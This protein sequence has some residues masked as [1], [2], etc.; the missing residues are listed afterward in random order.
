MEEGIRRV[1]S[2]LSISLD[3]VVESS[4]QWQ[5]EFDEQTRA[6]LTTTLETSD[7][8][9]VR[10]AGTGDVGAQRR[11]RPRP[12]GRLWSGGAS[13]PRLGAALIPLQK[14]ITGKRSR[15]CLTPTDA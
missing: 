4:N 7:A 13:G 15:T 5:V 11:R 12:L 10:R 2:G 14:I 3:G 6:A 1:V 8:V 9:P